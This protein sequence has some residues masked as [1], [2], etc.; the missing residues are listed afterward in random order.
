MKKNKVRK[1]LLHRETL[2]QL[3]PKMYSRV[4]GMWS[5][6]SR[7]VSDCPRCDG[8]PTTTDTTTQN[9]CTDYFCPYTQEIT[10]P[11]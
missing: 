10:C 8:E 9:T 1:L 5:D 6:A 2:R 4:A 7:C 11:V 3:D